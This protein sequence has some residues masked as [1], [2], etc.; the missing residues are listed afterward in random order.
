MYDELLD[1]W[2]VPRP[3]ELTRSPFGISNESYFVKSA[4]GEHVLRIYVSKSLPALPFEHEVLQRLMGADLPFRT[5]QP[6][7]SL[8]GETV[9]LDADTARHAALVRR[10]PGETLDDR[11][12][13]A[14][15]RA[16]EAFARLDVGFAAVERTDIPAPVFTGDLPRD[17][18]GDHRSGSAR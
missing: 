1:S 16:A 2:D 13:A 10:I 15:A 7:T 8:R 3:R 11:D 9:A 12:L 4:A 14:V 6:L 17:A 5:P 18:P